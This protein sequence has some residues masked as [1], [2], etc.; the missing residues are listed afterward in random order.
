MSVADFLSEKRAEIDTRLKELR[1]LHEEYLKLERAKAALDG[2]DTSPRRGPGR[3]R[4]S[5]STGSSDA[6]RRRNRRS[7]GTR[8]EQA[9]EAVRQNP[10]ITVSELAPK[11]GI[12]QKNYLYRVMNALQDDGAVQK[13]GRG[14][15]AV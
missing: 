6:R 1:P 7:G 9:L 4:G 10:G 15:V 5:A 14:Y 13:Q 8:S 2:L 11:L 3:P 12:K